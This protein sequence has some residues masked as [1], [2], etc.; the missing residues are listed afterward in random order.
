VLL[1]SSTS[2]PT[3]SSSHLKGKIDN[4]K[5]NKE[6]ICIIFIVSIFGL[7]LILQE[8]SLIRS[9]N[10]TTTTTAAATNYNSDDQHDKQAATIIKYKL[11]SRQ[12]Q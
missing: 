8:N 11:S 2:T 1:S 9:I 4:N 6:L 10:T 7:F 5:T 12:K 3:P